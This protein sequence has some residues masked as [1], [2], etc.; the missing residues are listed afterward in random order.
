MHGPRNGVPASSAIIL[1][2]DP[3]TYQE[4]ADRAAADERSMSNWLRRLVEEQLRA[5]R[6]AA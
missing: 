5:E 3:V 6:V 2:L 4:I 1:R